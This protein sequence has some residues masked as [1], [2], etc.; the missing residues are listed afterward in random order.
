[1]GASDNINIVT[2]NHVCLFCH[3]QP[4]ELLSEIKCKSVKKTTA[5]E[6]FSDL[7]MWLAGHLCAE[8]NISHIAVYFTLLSTVVCFI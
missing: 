6:H 2:L 4:N 8:N 7:A 5:Q 1:M 3:L